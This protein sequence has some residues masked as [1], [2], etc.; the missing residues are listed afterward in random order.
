MQ[1]KLYDFFTLANSE[2]NGRI[3]V[4]FCTFTFFS[5]IPDN[6]DS[7]PQLLLLLLF[8]AGTATVASTLTA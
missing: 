5:V 4:P 6:Y 7:F 1:L 8:G 2:R 3:H